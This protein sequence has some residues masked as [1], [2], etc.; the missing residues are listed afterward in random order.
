MC[1]DRINLS[2]SMGKAQGSRLA[3]TNNNPYIWFLV[4]LQNGEL[5]DRNT[6]NN[7]KR[8]VLSG[9]VFPTALQCFDPTNY[10]QHSYFVWSSMYSSNKT[11]SII[12]RRSAAEGSK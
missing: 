6:N 10:G 7:P 9:L 2:L 1:L 3:T 5:S 4:M 12:S 11:I 8:P